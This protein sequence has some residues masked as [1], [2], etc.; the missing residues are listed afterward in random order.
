MKLLQSVGDA[1]A[2]PLKCDN[3]SER[4]LQ[5]LKPRNV[6]SRDLHE[7]SSWRHR[8]DS[9][10]KNIQCSWSSLV[11]GWNGCGGVHGCDRNRIL[12]VQWCMHQMRFY[13]ISRVTPTILTW[14]ETWT[15]VPA[16]LA[17][18]VI[19]REC[20][21]WVVPN[22]TTSDLICLGSVLTHYS[23]TRY[24]GSRDKARVW[25][26]EYR[27]YLWIWRWRA[28]CRQLQEVIWTDNMCNGWD[29]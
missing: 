19:G 29:E 3:T 25:Q 18:E 21:R 8:G 24:A 13:Y 5:T 2:S 6:L 17:V 16:T 1:V 11:W 22:T 27:N 23:R 12:K 26:L 7:R 20:E 10:W 14:L 4:A 9:R 28:E 15:R